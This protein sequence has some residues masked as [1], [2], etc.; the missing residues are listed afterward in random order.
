MARPELLVLDEPTA[1]VDPLVQATFLELVG[2]ARDDGRPVFLSSHVLSE[3]QQVADEAI[4]IRAGKV[5]ATGR[6]DE[7]RQ[8]ARQPFTAWFAGA[9]PEDELRTATGVAQL[10]IHGREVSGVIEGSPNGFLAV[11]AHHP[12][13]HLLMPEPDLEQAFLRYYEGDGS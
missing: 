3:V 10:D 5:V 1:G 11:L 6:I 12:V 7:L 13:D 4:V 9:P 8:A 2:E